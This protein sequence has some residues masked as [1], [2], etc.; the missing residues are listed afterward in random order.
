MRRKD[1]EGTCEHCGAQF[2]YEIVHNGFNDSAS[3]Y[4]E[5]C[6][7]TAIVGL[8]K[9][10]ER[11]KSLPAVI[12]PMPTVLEDELASCSC[13]G[14]FRGSAPA[15]CPVCYQALSAELAANWLEAQAPG[16]KQ[17]WKWQRSWA[18]LYA[19][20]FGDRVAFDPWK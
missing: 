7:K 4:C 14:R 2:P 8:W 13:G 19:L 15:R 1:G 12:V 3:A 18:G 17:G 6:G 11:L 20:I 16:A 9:A 5:R 10:Q